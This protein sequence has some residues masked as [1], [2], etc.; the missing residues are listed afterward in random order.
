MR[1]F[2]TKDWIFEQRRQAY[3]EGCLQV[4]ECLKSIGFKG[5]EKLTI[6]AGQ[7]YKNTAVLLDGGRHALTNCIVEN[8]SVVFLEKGGNGGQK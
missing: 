4:V 8:G 5:A 3:A 6:H 1:L 7:T 2:A